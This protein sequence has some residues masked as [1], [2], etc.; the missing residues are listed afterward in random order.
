MF[1]SMT[2]Q[3]C[4][5]GNLAC[6][7]TLADRGRGKGMWRSGVSHWS[8]G[9]DWMNEEGRRLV[10][11]EEM[12]SRGMRAAADLKSFVRVHVIGGTYVRS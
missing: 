3:A 11:S 4:S 9:I 1:L 8:V 12:G 2:W 7:L 6:R 10:I 5:I